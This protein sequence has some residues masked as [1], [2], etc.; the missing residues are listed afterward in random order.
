MAQALNVFI[1]TNFTNKMKQY[2]HEHHRTDIVK[3]SFSSSEN[4]SENTIPYQVIVSSPIVYNKEFFEKLAMLFNMIELNTDRYSFNMKRVFSEIQDE[5]ENKTKLEKFINFIYSCTET[6][7]DIPV[8]TVITDL[9][10]K[11]HN[12]Q[13][14]QLWI[15]N[16]LIQ[17]ED[18]DSYLVSCL[19]IKLIRKTQKRLTI[20]SHIP[21]SLVRHENFNI[22][23]EI[24]AD[25][26]FIGDIAYKLFIDNELNNLNNILFMLSCFEEHFL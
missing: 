13:Y 4:N 18:S 11:I 23:A 26:S 6:N 20:I 17:N 25:K 22:L 12:K 7:S 3:Y 19:A 9:I 10:N 1:C 5:K 15:P 21:D 14:D 24:H 2:I 16:I 8:V